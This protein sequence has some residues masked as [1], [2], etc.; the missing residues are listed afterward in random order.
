M[1][2]V[3]KGFIAITGA[4][5]GIGKATARLFIEKGYNVLLIAR[6]EH[7]L[8]E[9]KGEQVLKASIDIRDKEAFK[10][11]LKD[12]EKMFGPVEL[13]V[14]NAG[15]MMLGNIHSQNE[16]EWQ[17]MYDVNVL[18]VLTGMQAVLPSMIERKSGT[19]VNI[20][21]IAGKKTFPNHGAYVGTKF[22][23]HSM[24]ENVREEVAE[25]NVRVITIAPGVVETELLSH[26][27]SKDIRDDYTNWKKSINGGLQPETVA[28]AIHFA[29]SQPQ[30]VNIREIVLAPT[31]QQA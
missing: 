18:G 3:K 13:L 4:S 5:S 17:E 12:A 30:H 2:H 11:S 25:H 14:N 24:S 28:E 31:K 6:R 1:I 20:S 23:V 10:N 9:F 8:D 15:R 21:S 26:T 29:F 16:S 19:I 27:T 22:A 7:L